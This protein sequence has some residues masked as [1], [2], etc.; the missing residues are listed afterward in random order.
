MFIRNDKNYMFRPTLAIIRVVPPL[1]YKCAY[2]NTTIRH[3]ADLY[4]RILTL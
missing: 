4:Y 3:Q 2:T 1:P